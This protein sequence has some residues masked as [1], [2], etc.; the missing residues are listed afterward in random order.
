MFDYMFSTRKFALI[1]ALSCL[2]LELNK[3]KCFYFRAMLNPIN[4]CN[5][6]W[7]ALN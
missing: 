7:K 2:K 5:Q 1:G 4:K 3:L 6:V